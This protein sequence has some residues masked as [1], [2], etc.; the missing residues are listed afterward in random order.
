[1]IK[2]GYPVKDSFKSVV[3]KFEVFLEKRK[4]TRN[5]LSL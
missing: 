3:I 4:L 1:M 5:T 2:L